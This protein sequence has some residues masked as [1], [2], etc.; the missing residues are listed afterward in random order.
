VYLHFAVI[1]FHQIPNT[2]D[3]IYHLRGH[4]LTSGPER[5]T[6]GDSS[7]L[8][9]DMS[10]P[11]KK[12]RTTQSGNV[13]NEVLK[14]IALPNPHFF[15][16]HSAIAGILHM[17]GAGKEIDAAIYRAGWFRKAVLV[18]DDLDR[19]FMRE[20]SILTASVKSAMDIFSITLLEELQTIL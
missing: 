10:P 15:R 19:L 16:I 20:R 5:I 9:S 7:V 8:C 13:G 12:Q 4:G 11:R 18:G 1:Q 14:G 17:S 2:Y 3:V 6:F